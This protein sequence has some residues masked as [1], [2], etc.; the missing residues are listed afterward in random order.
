MA[1][2]KFSALISNMVGKL[3][4]SVFS[5]VRGGTCLKNRT[6]PTQPNTPIQVIYRNA[7]SNISGSWKFL[8]EKKRIQWNQAAI[9]KFR[10]NSLGDSYKMNGFSYYCSCNLNLFKI[11]E[12]LIDEPLPDVYYNIITEIS[13]TFTILNHQGILLNL[14]QDPT[15]PNIKYRIMS[16][17][18]IKP[19]LNYVTNK[20]RCVFTTEK[21]SFGILNIC[22]PFITVFPFPSLGQKIFFKAIPIS[23]ISGNEFPPIYFNTIVIY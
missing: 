4:G 19:S 20:Y 6:I 8:D 21:S 18:G 7:L 11:A 23:C 16:T 13:V 15:D 22:L 2:V 14:H 12:P 1:L 3:N 9:G 5:H 17:G 10:T